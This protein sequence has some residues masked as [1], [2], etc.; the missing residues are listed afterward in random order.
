MISEMDVT[1]TSIAI[2]CLL[3]IIKMMWEGVMK[4]KASKT[5]DTGVLLQNLI[6]EIKKQNDNDKVFRRDFYEM[7]TQTKELHDWHNKDDGDGRKI[8][9][10]KASLEDAIIENTKVL[11]DNILQLVNLQKTIKDL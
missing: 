6:S 8:W 2:A 10:F 1:Q 9:Y 4:L 11:R 5:P 7:K 3:F